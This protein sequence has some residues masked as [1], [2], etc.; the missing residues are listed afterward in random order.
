MAVYK[1]KQQK[2][3]RRHLRIRKKVAGTAACPR[4][5][6]QCYCKQYILSIY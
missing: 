4:F 1:T 6:R 5:L 3:L 2:R